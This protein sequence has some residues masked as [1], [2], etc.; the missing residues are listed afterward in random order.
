MKTWL[1]S[2]EEGLQ[3]TDL[4]V[5]LSEALKEDRRIEHTSC[6]SIYVC[7]KGVYPYLVHIHVDGEERFLFVDSEQS[8]VDFRYQGA[9]PLIDALQ[10]FHRTKAGF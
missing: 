5:D 9:R 10:Q 3:P 1:Y 6:A 7:R 8:L 4:D 2:V